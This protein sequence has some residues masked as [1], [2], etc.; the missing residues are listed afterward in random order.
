MLSIV[1]WAEERAGVRQ[2]QRHT[3][4]T[5]SGGEEGLTTGTQG[6]LYAGEYLISGSLKTR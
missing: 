2:S 5:R 1:Q 4:H 6:V 3:T